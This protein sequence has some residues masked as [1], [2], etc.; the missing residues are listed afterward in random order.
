MIRSLKKKWFGS[1]NY[2]IGREISVGLLNLLNRSRRIF[3]KVRYLYTLPTVMSSNFLLKPL[4]WISHT[5][6]IQTLGIAAL[7][8]R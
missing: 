4:L 1:V 8:Q 7:E 3:S 6:Y 5:E 2:W